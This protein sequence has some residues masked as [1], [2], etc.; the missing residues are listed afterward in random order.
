MTLSA[1]VQR[2]NVALRETRG[3]T[4]NNRISLSVTHHTV[5]GAGWLALFRQ[6]LL[7]GQLFLGL[8]GRAAL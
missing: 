5:L 8:A 7:V 6:F 2:L 3:Q 4:V 1:I